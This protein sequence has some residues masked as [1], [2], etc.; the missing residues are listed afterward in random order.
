MQSTR[1]CTFPEC[2]KQHHARGYC[3]GHYEQWKRG[4][5]LVPIR[6][7]E[8]PGTPLAVRLENRTADEG[9]CRVWTGFRNKDGYGVMNNTSGAR[10]VHRAAYELVHG[11][12]PPGM[13]IDHMCHNPA[14][15]RVEHLQ[16]VTPSENSQNLGGLNPR[17]T[18]GFRGVYL[19]KRTGRYQ[20]FARS[21][22]ERFYGG[23]YATAEEA[24][25]SAVELRN[26]VQT[27]NLR[28]RAKARTSETEKAA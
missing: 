20:V 14:C 13:V 24:N 15:V 9:E 6:L 28:D 17:N 7:M 8:R 23:T 22:G 3:W 11:P 16:A 18:T 27:N 25:E 1:T 10:L 21:G 19:N 26:R 2:A 4:R 12:T 5:T